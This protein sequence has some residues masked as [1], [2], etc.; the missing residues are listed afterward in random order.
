[1][2]YI[3]TAD[4]MK[5]YDHNTTTKYGIPSSV[6]MERAALA[7]TDFICEKYASALNILILAGS[8]NNGGD[9]I[10][11]A[12]ILTER[13]IHAEILL[14]GNPEHMT[15]DT[16][17]QLKIAQA[18]QVPVLEQITNW[19]YDVYVDAIFGIGL[20]NPVKGKCISIIEQL[21]LL[22]KP[23]VSVDLPS[24]I[25]AT[26]GQ[27]LHTAVKATD[28]ITYGFMKAGLILYPGTTYAG[29]IH[30]MD[31]GITEHSIDDVKP[32]FYT[33]EKKDIR[34][35]QRNPAGNKGTFGK[36]F[37]IAGSRMMYGACLFSALSAYRTGAGMVKILTHTDN[38]P[39]LKKKL[40]EALLSCYDD[41]TSY[42]ELEKLIQDGLTWST[43]TA[44]GPGIGCDQIS[45]F[46]MNILFAHNEKPLIC[47][48][49]ALNI[50]AK[51]QD[52]LDNLLINHRTS[53]YDIVFTPHLAEFSRLCHEPLPEVKEH[54]FEKAFDF[55]QTYDITLACKDARSLVMKAGK[56]SY[57]N[58]TGN[59]GMATAGSGDVL[60]GIIAGLMAQ[61]MNGYDAS[62][63][64]EYLHGF[65]GDV[66]KTN[67]N[68]YY[69][70][71]QDIISSLQ[72]LQKEVMENE[73]V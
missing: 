49:D 16:L 56:A 17:M 31:I 19:N 66:A 63:M 72:Y 58:M 23:V 25:D 33:F 38:I 71:A 34:L 65:A 28:T 73:S 42:E 54:V 67:T 64:G 4:Q 50:I 15:D 30:C 69:I 37:L 62:C 40:P 10:A 26:T 27:I 24:G 70:M 44:V 13:N 45:H 22:S 29:E 52:I 36:L 18:Y 59:D 12:R 46:M 39:I 60:T 20:K 8:G 32:M 2:K 5:R 68:A 1:M 53:A 7:T 48:A 11:I 21:N 6:L 51:D 55:A 43:V 14:C 35:P 57:L 61:G 9:G 41:H 47:D 3:V